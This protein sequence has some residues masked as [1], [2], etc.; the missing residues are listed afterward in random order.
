MSLKNLTA[1]LDPAAPDDR[2]LVIE[3]SPEGGEQLRL[4]YGEGGSA[5]PPWRVACF[6]QSPT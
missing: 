5:S 2:P 3:L 1:I 6:L 4:S